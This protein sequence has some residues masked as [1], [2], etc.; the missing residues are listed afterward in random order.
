MPSPRCWKGSGPP[1]SRVR[2]AP[3]S[4][5]SALPLPPVTVGGL[6]VQVVVPSEPGTLHVR[7]TSELNPPTAAT[8]RLSVIVPP[9]E[10]A[11]AGLATVRV[12]LGGTTLTVT[13]ICSA[14]VRLP[15][16]AAI[17]TEP[18]VADEDALTVSELAEGAFGLT[19]TELGF[20]E[21]V[22]PVVPVQE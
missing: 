3:V 13:G 22:R 7:V 17:V 12:K 20:N 6:I 9:L 1:R 21:Q 16:V 19:D 8:V 4:V 2:T 14:W 15:P 10:I 18:V 5:I 11:T